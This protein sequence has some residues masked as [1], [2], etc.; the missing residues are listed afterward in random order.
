MTTLTSG[1]AHKAYCVAGRGGAEWHGS[2]SCP[3]RLKVA[4]MF[5]AS[6][7]GASWEK[8][9]RGGASRGVALALALFSALAAP[10]AAQPAQPRPQAPAPDP[11]FVAAETAFNA[12]PEAE[13]RGIQNDLIWAAGFQGAASGGYGPLTFRAINAFKAPAGGAAD[14]LLGPAERRALSDAARRA[15]EA[16]GFHLVADA[17]T[18]VRIGIPAAVLPRTEATPSGGSRWQSADGKVTLDTRVAP[19]GEGLQA[20][21]EKA[22]SSNIPG[23]RITYK[24]LRP[25]FYVVSGET[26]TGK[27]YS[28]LSASEAGLRGF[29]IGYDKALAARI[30]PLVI[31]I[32]ASFE[33]FPGRSAVPAV[34]T[35]PSGLPSASQQTL[36]AQSQRRPAGRFGVALAVGNGLALTASSAIAECNTITVAGHRARVKSK[37]EASG[38]ALLEIEGGPATSAPAA[39]SEAPAEGEDLLALGFG[40]LGEGRRGEVALPARATGGRLNAPLQPGGAGSAVFD[41]RG[42]LVGIVTANPSERFAVAGVVPARAYRM[43]QMPEIG[44]ALGGGGL[45]QAAGVR[46][47]LSTGAL[48]ALVGRSVLQVSCPP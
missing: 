24:L 15:R 8:A 4:T 25:D 39:R 20:L 43:A 3:L 5:G 26:P 22:V 30:D 27:F 14:G 21:F 42:Q 28:R 10:V 9:C 33:P 6:A 13:R 36:P 40:D 41:R 46:P 23:R 45:G 37:D 17:R 18:G 19:P 12:L 7:S 47:E 32:A 1:K 48:V 31:A 34:A 11:R 38:L 44:R 2:G 35:G 29:S 16:V